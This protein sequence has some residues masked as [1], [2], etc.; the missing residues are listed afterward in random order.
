MSLVASSCVLPQHVN[1]PT[2]GVKFALV[3]TPNA[4]KTVLW[5]KYCICFTPTARKSAA[6]TTPDFYPKWVRNGGL[7]HFHVQL[8]PKHSKNRDL[9]H[10]FKGFMPQTGE[11]QLFG[12][13]SPSDNHRA[14]SQRFLTKKPAP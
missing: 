9:G 10:N 6:Q 3:F 7:G 8:C 2:L 14:G 11:I 12:A 4:R 1:N 13:Q 5:D